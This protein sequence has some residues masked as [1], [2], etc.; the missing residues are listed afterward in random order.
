MK[1]SRLRDDN[2]DKRKAYL[3]VSISLVFILILTFMSVGFALYTQVISINGTVKF[4]TDGDFAITNVVKISSSNTTDALP[5]FTSDSID[6]N[7]EFVKSADPDAVYS[8]VYDITVSNETFFDQTINNF[9]F[10]FT[11]NN[12]QGNPSGTITYDLTGITSGDMVE[13]LSEK[14]ATLTITFV[15]T[16]DQDTY[17]INGEGHIDNQ[18]KPNGNMVA[19]LVGSTSGDVSEGKIASFVVKVTSTYETDRTFN[20]TLGNPK[21]EVCD[22]SG[23]TL[24]DFTI[25]ANTSDQNYTFYVK[26]KAGET[27]PTDSISTSVTLKSTG[28]PNVGC[29]N[30]TLTV[31]EEEVYVDTFAPVISNVTASQSNEI[32][33]VNLS[34]SG[35]DDYSGVD[36][37]T[38]LVLDGDNNVSRTLTTTA[39]ETQMTISGLSNGSNASTYSFVVY[40]IDNEGNSASQSDITNASTSAGYASSSGP[41]SYQWVFTVTF[42]RTG[43][44]TTGDA[45]V[46]IGSTYQ[47]TATA[48]NNYALP[49]AITVTMGGNNITDFTYNQNNGNISIPNV[50]G[51]L[52]ITIT[53]TYNG[54]V[55]C[56]VEGTYITL[57]DG[58]KKLVEDITYD[59]LLLV[60]DHEL[61]G[62]SYEY[63]IWM[64]KEHERDFYQLTTFDDGSSLKT[65][66][67][68]TVFNADTNRYA[69]L[70]T[71]SVGTSIYK[72]NENNEL[73][74]VKV[75]KIE[76][77]HKHIKYYDIV[78]TRF[79]NMIAD[80]V[81]VS[82][83]R[84]YLC[85]FYEFRENLLWSHR[86]EEVLKY[87]IQLDYND[88]N[89][90]PYYLFYGLRAQDGAVLVRYNYI[91]MNEFK[92]V[93]TDLL[94]NKQYIREPNNIFGKRIWSLSIDN[95]YK[96]KVF[97]G[98]NYILPNNKDVKC[99]LN[100]SNNE[101]YSPGSKVK[102][103]TGTHFISKY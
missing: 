25:P 91:S 2:F 90:V 21:L 43:V 85:N 52:V 16:V 42:N 83:G 23:N 14:V 69:D 50:T 9:D 78:S 101:C 56:L 99:Y 26:E 96:T 92:S 77:I 6:L 98:T 48:Q 61:G 30:I 75:E 10:S 8:A 24:N 93:F 72:L 67:P 31:D 20:F 28:L 45:T 13:K 11:V 51:N 41:G 27:F 68:H 87:N 94:L 34:W 97:E 47:A 29:G 60:F 80:D 49:N 7:L 103:W 4:K 66:G 71:I 82:D 59:D 63:P 15:P 46:N 102:I 76:T 35:E 44:N 64:E 65:V 84:E 86:R 88:F 19:S 18:E 12:N 33:V 73:Y 1:K 81:L 62:L 95:D 55:P 32:G 40:G 100:T 54:G 89:Y 53:G 5:F 57:A 17:P 38:V 36:H 39:D 74:K 79:Y 22:S 3:G 70:S 58:S 37:Y